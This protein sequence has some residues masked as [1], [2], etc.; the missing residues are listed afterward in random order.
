MGLIDTA[1]TERLE[2]PYEPG[3]WVE[4]RPLLATEM[5]E[6]KEAKIKRTMALWGDAL[7]DFAGKTPDKEPEDT[8]PNRVAQYDPLT[9][10]KYAV[11]KWSYDA[12][13]GL[14]HVE[15]LDAV[16]RDWLL[17]EVVLRNTR[18]L[19]SRKSSEGSSKPD[20]VPESLSTLTD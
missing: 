5:D 19:A 15:R 3:E 8:L 7:D 13:V 1:K 4:I 12:P 14:E 18:P 6:A 10:L 2:H 11:V 17:D 20:T 16:T 9:L